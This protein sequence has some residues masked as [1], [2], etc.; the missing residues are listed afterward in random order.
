MYVPDRNGYI[1][2]SG[3]AR[4]KRASQNAHVTFASFCNG[5]WL[6]NQMN[7]FPVEETEIVRR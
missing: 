2:E 7:Y 1:R 6:T 4:Q 3:H 5:T